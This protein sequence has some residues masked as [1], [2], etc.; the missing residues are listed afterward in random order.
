MHS[1][2]VFAGGGAAAGRLWRG[3]RVCP[4]G[5]RHTRAAC[6]RRRGCARRQRRRAPRRE[7]ARI[8][9]VEAVRVLSGINGE[10][11]F[12]RRQVRGSGSCSRM[13]SQDGSAL[14]RSIVV[15]TESAV[16][17]AGSAGTTAGQPSAMSC[18]FCVF[19]PLAAIGHDA[20]PAVIGLRLQQATSPHTVEHFSAITVPRIGA[21][22]EHRALAPAR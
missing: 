5:R 17:S 15:R 3:L 20:S 22:R 18:F 9:R 21:A 8:H 16:A 4:R 11:H 14:N 10:E 13:P 2:A 7:A 19:L 12:V 1:D 6:E